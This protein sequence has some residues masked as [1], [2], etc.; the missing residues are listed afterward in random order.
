MSQK[1]EI[2]NGHVRKPEANRRRLL[3]PWIKTFVW[4]F[5]ILG[6][7]VPA[8]LIFGIL[9]KPFSLA[10]YGFE[11]VAPL[12]ATGAVILALLAVKALISLGLWTEQKWAVDMA[13][14]DGALG[15]GICLLMMVAPLFASSPESAGFSFR[16]ELI[17]LIPYLIKM[18][19]IRPDWIRLQKQTNQSD[20]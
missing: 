16:L 11:T 19:K 2:L 20:T 3:P 13:I 4:I 18:L 1:S 10:L 6:L 9:G 7:A 5:M 8:S 12:S 15:I 14:I 17:V